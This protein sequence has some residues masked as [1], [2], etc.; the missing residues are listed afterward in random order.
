MK[1]VVI[2]YDIENLIGGYN[3][4]YLSEI[5]LKSIL[6][7]LKLNGINNIAVQ[8]AYADWSNPSLNSLKWDI[9][10]L[11]IEPIQMYGFSKGATKNASDI[12]LVIDAMEILHTKPFIDT[13]II[14][15]GDGGF[16]SLTKKLS[17][18]GKRVIGCAFK[19]TVNSVFKQVCDDFIYIE[20]TLSKEDLEKL[21]NIELEDT[22]KQAIMTN[23]ILKNIINQIDRKSV[24][25][26]EEVE[27]VVKQISNVLID[28]SLA[29]EALKKGMNISLIK[30]LLDYAIE[31][32]NYKVLGFSKL[33]D[34]LRFTLKNTPLKL[35]LKEPSEYRITFKENSLNNFEDVGFL[36]DAPEVHTV[37]FYKKILQSNKPSIFIPEINNLREAI[38]FML[39]NFNELEEYHF[40]DI[41]MNLVENLGIDEKEAER[42][43]NILYNLEFLIP[44]YEEKVKKDNFY[45][46]CASSFEEVKDA[47]NLLIENILKNNLFEVKKEVLEELKIV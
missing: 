4:K 37:N 7:K 35:V 33:V 36:L 6:N 42:I 31:D 26:I 12:Q 43:I 5:S 34:F 24:K 2:L 25:S 20:D 40:E 38:F 46:F 44:I 16:A 14:V 8:K 3:L 17:E 32:F 41:K 19:R 15:S 47:F 1:N 27:E 45:K 39:M 22:K 13:F 30:I 11:G 9:V 28:N 18:Y 29:K 10:E 21:K 23:P